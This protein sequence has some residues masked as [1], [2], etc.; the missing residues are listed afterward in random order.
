MV[1]SLACLS[2][3]R[4]IGQWGGKTITAAWGLD[5]KALAST[6]MLIDGFSLAAQVV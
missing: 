4:L 3:S 1:A 5:C 6:G 2:Q